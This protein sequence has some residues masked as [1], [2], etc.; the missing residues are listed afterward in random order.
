MRGACDR[1]ATGVA[2]AQE[3][4]AHPSSG[5]ESRFSSPKSKVSGG[6]M[7]HAVDRARSYQYLSGEGI[8][9]PAGAWVLARGLG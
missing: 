5:S 8:I 7:R 6:G 1:R 3:V 4:A 9:N 2:R